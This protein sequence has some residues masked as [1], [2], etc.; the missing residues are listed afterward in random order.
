MA[1][2]PPDEESREVKWHSLDVEEVM[3]FLKT[4]PEGLTEEE[5]KRRLEVYGPNEIS[6][7]EGPSALSIFL[8]QF[9]NCLLYTSPSPR[10]L[11]TS[12][13]PSSA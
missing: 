2:L 8:R 6:R 12:R 7:E 11:S 3:E 1:E 9:K 4:S 10:D 13:M 5:A